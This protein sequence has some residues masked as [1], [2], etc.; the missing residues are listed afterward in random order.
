MI[1]T[2]GIVSANDIQLTGDNRGGIIDT[3][4]DNTNNTNNTNGQN[5]ESD[6][7]K[8]DFIA[9]LDSGYVITSEYGTR[10]DPIDGSTSFHSGIDLC[11]P[12]HG[13][14]Y[15]IAD[16]EVTWAGVQSSYGN[17]VEI[18]HVVNGVEVYSFYAHMSRIDVVKGDI[19]KQGDVIGLEGGDQATDPNPGRTTGHH[20]HF[21]I[22]SA[23][24]Y[25]YNVN[26]HDYLEL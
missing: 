23:S 19:V 5:N 6:D 12:H 21:E 13:N 15:A 7:V 8:P 3:S 11:G 20:L 9:P 26:P 10:V 1:M 22:R 18:R 14:I 24:G 17:C 4:V 25:A 2:S 16:G